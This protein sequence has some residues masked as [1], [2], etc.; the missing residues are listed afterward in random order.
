[1]ILNTLWLALREIGRNALRSSLTVLGIII[2]VAAVISMVTLGGGATSQITQDIS[3]LGSNLLTVQ[4]G[5]RA[6]PGGLQTSAPPFDQAD[7]IAIGREIAGVAAVAPIASLPAVAVYGNEN[8]STTVTGSDNAYLAVREWSLEHGRVF[9]EGELRAGKL[10]CILGATVREEL[11][12]MHDPLG[13]SIRLGTLSCQVIG[14]LAPKGQA[15][16][17]MDMDDFIL[18]PLRAFQR[19][20]AGNDDVFMIFVSS[21]NAEVT[22]RVQQDIE[23]LLG[24]RRRIKSGAEYDF[25]VQDMAEIASTVESTTA[26]LTAFLGAIAAISLLVGG[27]G[28][29]NV[30]LVSV[31]ERTREI[32]TRLAIGALGREVLFQFLVEAVL[33]SLIGGIVGIALGLGIAVGVAPMLGIPFVFDPVIVA[34]AFTFSGV[35]GVLFGYIPARRAARLDPIEALRYE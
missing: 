24:Q 31:T 19:R 5:T 6:R 35:V 17:G 25:A 23:K 33:L 4:P 11:F 9:S 12:G 18:T 10:V 27:I 1:M 22:T 20:I 28:V 15:S 13:A 32:G 34:I 29:M 7:A 2:G 3:S 16:L 30:M 21:E 14:V 26:I 8:T